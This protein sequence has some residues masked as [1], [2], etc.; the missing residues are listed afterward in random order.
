MNSN[1]STAGKAIPEIL[2]KYRTSLMAA[3]PDQWISNWTAD[4]IQLP[5]GGPMVIGRQNLYQNITAWLESHNVSEFKMWDLVI[6]EMG[7][8]AL[9]LVKYSYHL[10]PKDGRPD[11][12]FQGKA[13]TI[14]QHQSDGTWKIHRDCFNSSSPTR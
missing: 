1:H 13:L 5:P 6:E 12:L 10:K 11:Y 3:D 7:D 4:C 14:Y 9:S 8:R 2:D